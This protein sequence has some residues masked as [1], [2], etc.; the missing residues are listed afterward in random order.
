MDSIQK[1]NIKPTIDSKGNH[2]YI[3]NMGSIG[4]EGGALGSQV[5][6]SKLQLHFEGNTMKIRSAYPI[7]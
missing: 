3:V 5:S 2:S 7:K 6:L 1:N 4:N